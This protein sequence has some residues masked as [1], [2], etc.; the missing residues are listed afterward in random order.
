M[1]PPNMADTEPA[2]NK[3]PLEPDTAA[4]DAG[5]TSASPKQ[6]KTAAEASSFLDTLGKPDAKP[7]DA[8]PAEPET[9]A[10]TPAPL[11]TCPA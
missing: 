8:K 9:P 2:S 11:R 10:S 6:A 7:A 5:A 4:A 3:R 1:R